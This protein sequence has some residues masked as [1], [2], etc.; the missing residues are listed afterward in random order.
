MMP[1]TRPLTKVLQAS[2][3][4]RV[5]PAATQLLSDRVRKKNGSPM[6]AASIAKRYKLVSGF[7][8]IGSNIQGYRPG[9]TAAAN[10]RK[11]KM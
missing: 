3:R 10:P 5:Y 2:L 7:N 9:T 1:I 6:R 4:D 8:P 11:K